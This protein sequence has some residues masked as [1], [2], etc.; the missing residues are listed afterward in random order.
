MRQNNLIPDL[1]TIHLMI[2]HISHEPDA[3][4]DKKI[5]M[6]LQKL[7]E[8]REFGHAP[9]LRTFNTCLELIASLGMY[10]RGIP[11]SLDI[12]KEMESL[13][14]EPSLGTYASILEIFYPNK[15]IG[16][17]TGILGQII[18]EVEKMSQR[19]GG[20][21][22]RDSSDASFFPTAMIKCNSGL[23]TEIDGRVLGYTKRLHEICIKDNNIRFLNS[24]ALYNKYLYVCFCWIQIELKRPYIILLYC[25]KQQNLVF[26]KSY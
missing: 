15:D 5:E 9:N 20:I 7:R 14:I 8:I 1:S 22:W 21:E 24:S 4:N 16:S 10:Q 23:I 25:I 19:P 11:L 2:S 13:E 26:P 12:L 6:M 17:K 18:E 3:R